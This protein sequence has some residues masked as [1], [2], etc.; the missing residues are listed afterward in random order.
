MST[1][2]VVPVEV[3]I[4]SIPLR[5]AF[6]SLAQPQVQPV[7]APADVNINFVGGASSM[8]IPSAPEMRE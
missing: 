5:S 7:I 2:L 8:P 4:G 6:A 3:I 1:R